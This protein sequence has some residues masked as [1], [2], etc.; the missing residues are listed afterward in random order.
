MATSQT[1]A[2]LSN[3]AV[4][5]RRPSGEKSIVST[6]SLVPGQRPTLSTCRSIPNARGLVER[7]RADAAVIGREVTLTT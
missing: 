5:T 1:R 4:T 3:E 6:K 7:R 2:V